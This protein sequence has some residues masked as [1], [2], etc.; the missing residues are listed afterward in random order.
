MSDWLEATEK[1][2]LEDYRSGRITINQFYENLDCSFTADM[3]SDEGNA[4]TQAY[5]D[6]SGGSYVKDYTEHLQKG[7]PSEFH[8]PYTADNEV[9][10]HRVIDSRFLAWREARASAGKP[11]EM[12]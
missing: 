8:V 6:F 4:F 9:A 2:A 5:F 10:I 11:S 7:L 12:A 1:M 3:L